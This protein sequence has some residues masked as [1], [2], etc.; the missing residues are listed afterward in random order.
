M[1]RRH[2]PPSSVSGMNSKPRKRTRG[3]RRKPPSTCSPNQ[4]GNRRAVANFELGGRR[5]P[6]GTLITLGMGAANRDPAM[7]DQPDEFRLDLSLIHI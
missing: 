1:R 7:F 5:W 4:L 2:A 3:E 6:A